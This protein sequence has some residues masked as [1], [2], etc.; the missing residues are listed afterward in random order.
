MS[1]DDKTADE[2]IA[3]FLGAARP[4]R[5]E[6]AFNAA[7]LERVAKRE[8][9]RSL[10]AVGGVAALGGLVLWASAPALAAIAVPVTQSLTL[11]GAVLVVTFSL[12]ALGERTIRGR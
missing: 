4:E 10:G 7:V 5:A 8:L 1:P 6:T 11:G 12:L 2:K 9:F 3:A